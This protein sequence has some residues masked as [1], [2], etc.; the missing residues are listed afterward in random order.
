MELF[1]RRRSPASMKRLYNWL[2]R[3]YGPIS[4]FLEPT[5]DEVAKTKI[6][7]LKNAG[8]MT[9]VDYACGAGGWTFKLAPHFLSVTGR[10]QA[11]GMLTRAR[12]RAQKEGLTVTFQEGS[13][14]EIDEADNSFDWV[15]VSYALHLFS[16]DTEIA[17]LKNLLR[18]ARQGVMVIDHSRNWSP[19]VALAEWLE[20]SHYDQFIRMDFA[21]VAQQLGALSFEEV[22]IGDSMVLTFGSS[23]SKCPT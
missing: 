10:D 7:T 22:A 23:S 9:A 19:G 12:E 15:F 2:H 20:G 6:A 5:L 13:L 18:V 4:S 14:L 17:I 21:A 16:K 3:F 8:A 1:Q 11:T